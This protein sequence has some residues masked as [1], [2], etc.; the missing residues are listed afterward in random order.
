MVNIVGAFDAAARAAHLSVGLD[1]DKRRY[2]AWQREDWLKQIRPV[3][4]ELA[5]MFVLGT[6]HSDLFEI[7]RVLRNTVHGEGL[8]AGGARMAGA[9]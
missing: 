5:E 3:A 7:C 8:Q 1:P 4:P 6:P 2:A 9:T